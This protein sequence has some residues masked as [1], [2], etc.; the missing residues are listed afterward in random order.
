MENIESLKGNVDKVK[1]ASS[2]AGGQL[3]Q[4]DVDAGGK[5]K[6]DHD[7]LDDFEHLEHDTSPIQEIKD[8][9][10][11]SRGEDQVPVPR[12]LD[13]VHPSS[14][15]KHDVPSFQ[16]NLLDSS[17]PAGE[18][19]PHPVTATPPPS[20]DSVKRTLDDVL[21]KPINDVQDILGEINFAQASEP[22]QPFYAAPLPQG[23]PKAA[24]LA[25][26]DGERSQQN[27][28]KQSNAPQNVKPAESHHQE[29]QPTLQEPIFPEIISGPVSVPGGK[30]AAGA[31]L[32]AELQRALEAQVAEAKA[33]T[34][35]KSESVEEVFEDLAQAA[36]KMPEVQNIIDPK[37]DLFKLDDA[38]SDHRHEENLMDRDLIGQQHGSSSYQQLKKPDLTSV[39]QE[40]SAKLIGTLDFEDLEVKGGKK[41]HEDFFD[42]IKSSVL[43]EP[44][45]S[46]EIDFL[47]DEPIQD[48]KES[49][50]TYTQQT[51]EDDSWNVV[52][53]PD[54]FEKCEPL[55]KFDEREPTPEPPTKSLPPIPRDAS[56]EPISSGTP[57]PFDDLIGKLGPSAP[58]K[59]E[60][61]SDFIATESSAQHKFPQTGAET[62]DSEFESE[63]ESCPLVPPSRVAQ[64][65]PVMKPE[66]EKPLKK[67]CTAAG[68]CYRKDLV[69]EIA[70][71]EIFREM[72]LG[73]YRSFQIYAQFLAR[74]NRVILKAERYNLGY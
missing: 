6:R 44:Q 13:E 48:A 68:M 47:K 26:M 69:E 67:P 3:H 37:E 18:A 56:P 2:R 5:L 58:E 42:E 23:D 9:A 12:A 27:Y 59:Y 17:L 46:P 34:V 7:S 1:E 36:L 11:V 60:L 73:E 28:P 25:F 50:K 43:P 66:P 19:D 65:E 30:A 16:R 49:G 74:L 22:F 24:S 10:A 29:K 57:E 64:P 45:K 20:A 63:P 40:N 32:T 14:I 52:E 21:D 55:E 72:G 70:P 61:S 8:M 53:K 39:T 35:K 33:G 54:K 62:G 38:K 4:G 51:F 71:K 15:D 41:L 31:D